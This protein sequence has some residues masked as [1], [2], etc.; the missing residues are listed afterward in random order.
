MKNIIGESSK[1][2]ALYHDIECIAKTNSTILITGESGT[3]KELVAEA[4]HS[5]SE[6]REMPLWSG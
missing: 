5:R 1:M 6:R 3:G 4:I 2:L